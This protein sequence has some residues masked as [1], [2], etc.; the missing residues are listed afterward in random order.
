MS[1]ASRPAR[2]PTCS[3]RRSTRSP[4][5]CT[6]P[7]ATLRRTTRPITAAPVDAATVG[8]FVRAYQA[9]DLPALVSLL[10]DDVFIAMPPIPYEYQGRAAVAGFCAALFDSGRRF[11]LHPTGANGQPAFV[12]RL[13]SPTGETRAVGLLV[14][15]LR[16][17]RISG[18]TRFDETVLRRFA[19]PGRAEP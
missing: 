13:R 19:G 6:A 5:P 12:T 18:L 7:G 10:T 4:A 3:T 2:S 9:A 11:E 16:G 14:L 1:S 8:R 15:T 17:N